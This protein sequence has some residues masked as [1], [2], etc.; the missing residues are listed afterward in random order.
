M[1]R[2]KK[3]E[4]TLEQI[5]SDVARKIAPWPRLGDQPLAARREFESGAPISVRKRD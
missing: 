5:Q 2:R 4:R 1:A 3:R